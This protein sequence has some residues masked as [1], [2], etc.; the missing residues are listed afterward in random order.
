MVERV[1]P[2]AVAARVGLC[3]KALRFPLGLPWRSPLTRLVAVLASESFLKMFA[4]FAIADIRDFLHVEPS[5]MGSF[6]VELAREAQRWIPFVASYIALD[7]ACSDSSR[8][9][10]AK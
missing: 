1:S 9:C 7:L 10:G 6:N 2:A 8:A 5:R 4:P 3:W